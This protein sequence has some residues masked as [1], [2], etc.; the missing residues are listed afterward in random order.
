VSGESRKLSH[1][2]GEVMVATSHWIEKSS[3]TS[4][5]PDRICPVGKVDVRL[6]LNFSKAGASTN[7]MWRTCDK[8]GE[9]ANTHGTYTH[10]RE[11]DRTIASK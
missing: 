4:L 1:T 6:N 7:A 2:V 3:G 11:G 8:R 9:L 5:F 10:S